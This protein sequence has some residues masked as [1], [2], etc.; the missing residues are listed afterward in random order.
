MCCYRADLVYVFEKGCF[1][2]V[3]SGS[4]PSAIGTGFGGGGL[5][6]EALFAVP[7]G[8]TVRN[9]PRCFGAT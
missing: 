4:S 6:V 2:V 1:C 5:D 9:V 7:C 8:L 3:Y